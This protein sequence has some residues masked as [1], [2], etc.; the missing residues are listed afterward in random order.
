MNSWEDYRGD[1]DLVNIL[2]KVAFI[3]HYDS[4]PDN[5]TYLTP[6][7][8]SRN[9]KLRCCNEIFSWQNEELLMTLVGP[10]QS[11]YFPPPYMR[12]AQA[13]RMMVDLSMPTELT[14]D[15]LIRI[16][17]DIES[18]AH[19]IRSIFD[20]TSN[21]SADSQTRTSRHRDNEGER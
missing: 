14:K 9:E 8:D 21:Y 11:F 13:H 6:L 3:P 4:C 17:S 5:E 7:D 18:A 10:Y 2:K 15:G 20:P 16:V 1:T 12:T 19:S